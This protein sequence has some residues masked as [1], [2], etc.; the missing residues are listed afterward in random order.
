[1]KVDVERP[2][3][4]H[5]PSSLFERSGP[6]HP[7]SLIRA[8]TLAHRPPPRSRSRSS[9]AAPTPSP[10]PSPIPR[11]RPTLS[12]GWLHGCAAVP[13][14]PRRARHCTLPRTLPRPTALSRTSPSRSCPPSPSA[15]TTCCRT[16]TQASRRQALVPVLVRTGVVMT[17]ADVWCGH[18]LAC[19]RRCAFLCGLVWALAGVRASVCVLVWSGVGTRWRACAGV[20]SCVVWCE[21]SLACVRRCAFLCGLAGARPRGP[22]TAHQPLGLAAAGTDSR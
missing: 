10:T 5:S 12:H 1:M 9:L 19:V 4:T 21:H 7:S 8:L 2:S 17:G 22:S 11:R 18:S 3:L 14:A 15:L 20:R 13:A 16:T 6:I